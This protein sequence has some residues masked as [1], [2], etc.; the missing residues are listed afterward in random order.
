MSKGQNPF[1]Q[2][3]YL[4]IPHS[5]YYGKLHKRKKREGPRADSKTVNENGTITY[6]DTKYTQ[7]LYS[8]TFEGSIIC[9]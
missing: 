8:G 2:G 4:L 5:E 9:F 6:G 1:P 7:N 3:A